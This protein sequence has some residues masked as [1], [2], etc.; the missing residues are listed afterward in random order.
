[1]NKYLQITQT[2]MIYLKEDNFE[3][4]ADQTDRPLL[5]ALVLL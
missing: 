4:P 2:T 5:C 3:I 1:M